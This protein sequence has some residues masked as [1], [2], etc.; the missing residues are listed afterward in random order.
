MEKTSRFNY[1]NNGKPYLTRYA[2]ER[3]K[4]LIELDISQRK[5]EQ[6]KLPK[7]I[8]LEVVGSPQ[9]GYTVLETI[10]REVSF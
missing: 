9:N 4:E 6:K 8:K 7:K 1:D 10:T 3:R 5:M 2:A